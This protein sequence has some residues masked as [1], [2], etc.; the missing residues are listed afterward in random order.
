MA[1][2]KKKLARG[3]KLTA[4]ELKQAARQLGAKGGL[5]KKSNAVAKKASTTV[6]KKKKL[7]ASNKKKA[8]AKKKRMKSN[9]WG[10]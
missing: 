2:A 5:K 10:V 9:F 3:K 1:V 7:A 4:T 6:A 8:A